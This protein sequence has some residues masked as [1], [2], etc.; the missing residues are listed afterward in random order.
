MSNLSSFVIDIIWRS[1]IICPDMTISEIQKAIKQQKKCTLR[2]VQRYLVQLSIKPV[3]IRQRPQNY[4][5]D[6]AERIKAHLGLGT[7]AGIN[8]RPA[9]FVGADSLP[10]LAALK[11]ISRQAKRK[12]D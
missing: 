6:T 5:A 2:T 9:P 12:A 11:K 7:P 3:G 4:P 1:V 10:S 8:F